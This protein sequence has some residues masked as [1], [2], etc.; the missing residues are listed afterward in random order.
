MSF[1]CPMPLNR[2]DS[3]GGPTGTSERTRSKGGE[4]ESNRLG[5][6]AKTVVLQNQQPDFGPVVPLQVTANRWDRN[7]S[8]LILRKW[9]S[10]RSGVCYTK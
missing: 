3:I 10:A 1:V 5:N 2:L 4:N 9:R 6:T 8:R 7:P